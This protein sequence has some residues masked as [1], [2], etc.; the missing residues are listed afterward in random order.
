MK[1]GNLDIGLCPDLGNGGDVGYDQVIFG[2]PFVK[3]VLGIMN[4]AKLVKNIGTAMPLL[5][6][7]LQECGDAE[8]CVISYKQLESKCGCSHETLKLWGKRLSE[9][10]LVTKVPRGPT[11]VKFQLEGFLLRD[12]SFAVVHETTSELANILTGLRRTI[13]GTLSN[14]IHYVNSNR[15]SLEENRVVA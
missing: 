12:M 1:K 9:L 2:D 11:G 3:R 14:A 4:D 6:C 5:A 7:V 8:T 15:R 13:D 10:G